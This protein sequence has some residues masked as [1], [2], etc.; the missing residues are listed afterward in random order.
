MAIICR[1][2][3]DMRM[4]L[5]SASGSMLVACA[6]SL[7]TFLV[8][9]ATRPETKMRLVSPEGA[10][11]PGAPLDRA[12]GKLDL[13]NTPLQDAITTLSRRAG[14]PIRIHTTAL[15]AAGLKLNSRVN[16]Q[17]TDATLGGALDGV[18]CA[19]K[20]DAKLDYWVAIDGIEVSTHDEEEAYVVTRV[21]DVRDILKSFAEQG[22]DFWRSP[23]GFVVESTPGIP[24]RAA[25]LTFEEAQAA[26]EKLVSDNVAAQSWK[27]NGGTTGELEC[28]FGRLVVIQTPRNQDTVEALLL[29][30]AKPESLKPPPQGIMLPD[31]SLAWSAMR[32]E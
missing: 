6:S 4:V 19:V 28:A 1:A 29:L 24:P 31:H 10:F 3:R 13:E 5:R 26:L 23:T 18:L 14:V 21:Y 22:R 11:F 20:T 12:I 15:E 27:M 7:I 9:A 17:L 2:I 30:L 8:L 25:P 16:V 32:K